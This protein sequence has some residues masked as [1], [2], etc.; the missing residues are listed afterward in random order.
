MYLVLARTTGAVDVVDETRYRDTRGHNRQGRPILFKNTKNIQLGLRNLSNN[1]P[2]EIIS[3]S[4]PPRLYPTHAHRIIQ[5]K[6]HQPSQLLS[7]LL[8]RLFRSLCSIDR[9]V[10]TWSTS[11]YTARAIAVAKKILLLM[12]YCCCCTW[13][14]V[15]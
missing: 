7:P 13:Y 12:H 4:S 2:P 14:L 10:P 1:Q 15:S 5:I 9:Y 6:Y 8:S 11:T 3:V